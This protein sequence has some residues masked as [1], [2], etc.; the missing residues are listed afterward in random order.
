MITEDAWLT[1]VTGRTFFRVGDGTAPAQAAA[2][3]A[4]HPGCSYHTRVACADAARAVALADAGFRVV[5]CG[6]T[7]ERPPDRGAA[8]PAGVVM[9]EATHAEAVAEIGGS[10][11]AT[12]RFHLDPGMPPGA[13]D[14]IKREWARNCAIGARGVGVLVAV[15]DGAPAGF[16]SVLAAADGARVIDLVAV[17]PAHRGRGLGRAL[18]DAFVARFSRDATALRVGTQAANITSLR[19]YESCGF[20]V[21][22]T[23]YAMHLHT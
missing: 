14:A 18:V 9:A 13:A 17:D 20:R 16:L 4:A 6:V 2:H 21:A 19:L 3:A 7:L 23:A 1:G 10:A 8:A 12:S 11:F 5:D 15:A 22:A